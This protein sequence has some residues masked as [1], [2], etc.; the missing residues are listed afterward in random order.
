MNKVILVLSDALRYDTAVAQMGYLG[1]LV[2]TSQASLYRVTGELPSMSRPMYETVHTGQPS[3]AHGITSNYV[4][5]RSNQPNVFQIAHEA[6]KVTAAAAYSWFSELYNRAPYDRIE[7]REV[8]DE[9]LAIQ[10]GRFYSEDDYPDVE[11]FAGAALL[12]RRF[13]PDYL[14]VHPM[15]MDTV[16][17]EFGSD[18]P[19]YR[20]QA[21]LQDILLANLVPEWLGRGYSVL[22]TGD[23]GIDEHGA[24]GGTSGGVRTVPLFVIR[25]G[26]PGLGDSGETIP[27]LQ[28]APTVL[29]LLGLPIPETMKMP[30]LNLK[31][32]ST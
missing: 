30:P 15:G 14:L 10:H 19:E 25:P 21:I 8:D 28:I 13:T 11:L 22:V 20:K 12:V 4:V 16:G 27:M 5:R 32:H 24:H 2:E 9:S 1:H 26:L 3:S 29:A 17:E 31:D 7:D 6:G 18:S 23:H